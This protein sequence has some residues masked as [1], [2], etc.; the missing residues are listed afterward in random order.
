MFQDAVE[1]LRVGNKPRAKE[2]I[3]LLLKADQNNATYWVWLSA[4]MDAPKERAY[5][6]QTALKLDP[7][8]NSAKRG[9]VLLGAMRPDETIQPFPMNHPR[10]WEEKLILDYEKPRPTGFKAII[11]SPAVKLVGIGA[12]GVAI[13]GLAIFALSLP[14]RVTFIAPNTVTPGPSPTFTTT[15][16]MF[17]A[18]AQPTSSLVGPTPLWMLLPATYTPTPI[19]ATTPHPASADQL[20]AAK[21]DYEKGRWESFITNMKEIARLENNPPDVMYMI[22]EAYRFQGNYSEAINF[23]NAALESSN[24]FAPAYLGLARANLMENPGAKVIQYLDKAVEY[25]PNF[26]EAYLERANY[27]IARGDFA[28]ALIELKKASDLM[29]TSPMV[30]LAYAQAYLAQGNFASALEHALKAKD[31]DIT[32]LPIYKM[33]GEIYVMQKEYD[34]GIESL[35]IFTERDTTDGKAFATLAE[36]YYQTGDYEM[37]IE[38]A[39]HAIDHDVYQGSAYLYRGYAYMQQKQMEL[40][41]PDLEEAEKYYT[42]SFELDIT[43]T[44]CYFALEKYGSALLKVTHA[45]TLIT[46]SEEEAL[47]H[48]WKAKVAEKRDQPLEAY[49][50][51]QS[52]LLMPKDFTTE[53]MRKEAQERVSALA[54][55][56]PTPKPTK[57]GA[58]PTPTK[59]G[60]TPTP[61]KPGTGKTT[62]TPT[63]KPGAATT[64]ITPTS[65]SG[66]ATTTTPTPNVTVTP[67]PKTSATPTP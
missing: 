41:E 63:L 21:I 22:G 61:T 12:I 18:T 6:L 53:E 57:K 5:C 65:K 35:V 14:E 4:A 13:I 8:N 46:T 58:A 3:T 37:T 60:A 40:A 39:T 15:P 33:I 47:V 20:R 52:L 59:K 43:L 49:K 38:A 27:F 23:Y 17:G 30:E 29:P 62:I 56:T 34:K 26:G 51:W 66:A 48:Y 45:D 2:L 28:D 9:L 7:E 67:T 1:A 55:A 42:E 16:T 25:D 31:M 64:T 44:K 36:A 50:E 19:Y 11:A 32:M 10:A 54:T 24:T